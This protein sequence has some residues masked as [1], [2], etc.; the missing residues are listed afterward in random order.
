MKFLLTLTLLF[1]LTSCDKV[2]YVERECTKIKEVLNCSDDYCRVL[3]ENN[4]RL[5]TGVTAKG[6]ILCRGSRIRESGEREREYSGRWFLYNSYEE[7][8]KIEELPCGIIHSYI[9]DPKERESL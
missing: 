9:K 8:C 5:T 7:V 2:T 1:I 3:L 4:E 6:D